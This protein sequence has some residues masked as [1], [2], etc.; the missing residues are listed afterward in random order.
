MGKNT[1]TPRA[2]FKPLPI[3]EITL[4]A[5]RF[6][7]QLKEQRYEEALRSLHELKILAAA[8]EVHLKKWLQEERQKEEEET[9][10]GNL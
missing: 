7:T 8:L 10:H 9:R 2:Q 1:E 5:A 6:R 3:D 4:K